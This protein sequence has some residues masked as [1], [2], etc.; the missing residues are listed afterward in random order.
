MTQVIAMATAMAAVA[1]C[2]FTTTDLGVAE[3]D[4]RCPT[5]GGRFQ[6]VGN[7]TFRSG[8]RSAAHLMGN[9]FIEH[10]R[11]SRPE[12]DPN[13]IAVV[14][15]QPEPTVLYFEAYFGSELIGTTV[16]GGL[17]GWYCGNQTIVSYGS[18]SFSTEGGPVVEQR[19]YEWAF[20]GR[21][22]CY[23]EYVVGRV[24]FSEGV[25]ESTSCFSPY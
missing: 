8:R 24:L 6:E 3:V 10:L 5:V 17:E 12:V 19:L 15:V 20:R 1:G 7:T 22:L 25:Y 14:V 23:R 9:A 4:Q 18:R 13:A 16:A 2:T 11:R 21:E